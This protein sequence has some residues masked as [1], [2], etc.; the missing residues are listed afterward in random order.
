LLRGGSIVKSLAGAF[1]SGLRETRLTTMLGYAIALCPSEFCEL[2][3][4]SGEPRSVSLETRH[5]ADRSD[6]L[7]ETSDG[8]GIIE[9]KVGSHDPFD[10]ASKYPAR[11]RVLLTEHRPTQREQARR[12]RYLRWRGL[13]PVLDRFRKS[14][15]AGVRFINDDLKRYLEEHNMIPKPESIEIYARELN[16][17]ATVT[18]FL[19]GRMYGCKYKEGSRL[20]EALYFAP[21]FG[22]SVTAEYPAINYGISYLAK[23]ETVEVVESFRELCDRTTAIRGKQWFNSHKDLLTPVKA[24]PDWAEGGRVSFLFLRP[25][26]LVFN[27]PIRKDTLQKGKGYLSRHFFSFEEFFLA[28][29]K[30]PLK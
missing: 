10:Q 14:N 9:A 22:Q 5:A 25:P 24:W 16:D 6:I 13:V 23:L 3:G 8:T 29:G 27:P 1:G 21:H 15:R 28:W 18:L 20:P 26:Q 12:C 30:P 19:H 4:F 7:V 2:F 17:E 11:W